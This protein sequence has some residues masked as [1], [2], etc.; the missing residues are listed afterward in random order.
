MVGI[1]G[2]TT[3]TEEQCLTVLKTSVHFEATETIPGLMQDCLLR[4][5][6]DE[7]EGPS[8]EAVRFDAIM[9]RGTK[10]NSEGNIEMPLPF[11]RDF[12]SMPNNRGAV[13]AR[14]MGTL[15]SLKKNP[16]RLADCCSA[17]GTYWANGQIE[18]VQPSQINV[19]DGKSY[20]IP[21]F[22]VTNEKKKKTRM[23][24]DASA[25]YSG[26]SLNSVLLQGEDRNNDLRDV[27]FRFRNGTVAVSA[28]VE[29]MFHSFYLPETHR[30][31]VKFFW[32][33]GNDPT[34][35]VVQWRAKVHVFGNKSS[36]SCAIHGLRCAMDYQVDGDCDRDSKDLIKS[37]TY[38]DD[39][40]G[41]Y[42][43]VFQAVS[44]LE[45]ARRKLTRFNIR[46]HKLASNSRE[47]IESFPESEWSK[48]Y[49][50]EG[51]VLCGALGLVWNVDLD[52]LLSI[53]PYPLRTSHPEGS[54]RRS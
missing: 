49:Q 47:V 33:H 2:V 37:N 8:Q 34:Q 46:L 45:G 48:E 22:A 20:F 18:E 35:P 42:D 5:P 15:A 11:V 3:Q 19:P 26:V 44:A 17:M 7:L 50:E 38:V 54:S 23:V 1:S 25:E 40:L 53:S 14:T 12:P 51:E 28:D 36:P 41:A 24:F 10:V 6:D 21:I 29:S 13:Y 43:A 52:L 30:N 32:F 27:L 39:S 16:L 31:Y 9:S 4:L